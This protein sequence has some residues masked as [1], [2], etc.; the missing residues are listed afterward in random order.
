MFEQEG[1]VR[2]R[3][4]NYRGR[5][6]TTDDIS[7]SLSSASVGTSPKK[8]KG[9]EDYRNRGGRRD[10]W[11]T[12]NQFNLELEFFVYGKKSIP[13]FIKRTVPF[14]LPKQRN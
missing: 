9:T 14:P 11:C 2:D 13:G 3:L 1:T 12:V 6:N 10:E 4:L 7:L 5:L 8:Y